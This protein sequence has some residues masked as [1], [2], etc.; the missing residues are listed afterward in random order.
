MPVYRKKHVDDYL[1]L[2]EDYYWQL[3]RA[4]EGDPP[5]PNM[6][7]DYFANPDQFQRD[8]VEIDWERVE[9][10]IKHFK[11]TV[12]HMRELKKKA[13]KRRHRH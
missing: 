3:R 6:A 4:L 8:F 10:Q 2:L 11:V 13:V 12:E 9:F 1:R 5:N 7:E